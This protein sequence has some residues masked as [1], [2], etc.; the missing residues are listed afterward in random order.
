MSTIVTDTLQ[1]KT[2]A[3]SITLP[4]TTNI[5]STPLVSASANSMTIRGEGSATTNIQQGLAKTWIT[6][7]N[8]TSPPTIN[9]SFNV[10]ST[11]DNGAGDQTHRHSND[12]A[13]SRGYTVGGS[14]ANNNNVTTTSYQMQPLSWNTIGTAEMRIVNIYNTDTACNVSDYHWLSIHCHGD[15]A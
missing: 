15:L 5:G 8:S 4:T 10:S 14:T 13:T 6:Y 7:G 1:G 2:S 9:D 11:V 12:M 3:T